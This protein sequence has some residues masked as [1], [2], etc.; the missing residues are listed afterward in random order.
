M[1]RRVIIVLIIL[2]LTSWIYMSKI[3]S[4]TKP[5]IQPKV[6]NQEE[7]V[8]KVAEPRIEAEPLPEPTTVLDYLPAVTGLTAEDEDLLV[9]EASSQLFSDDV[10]VEGF[11][12]H[13]RATECDLL[14]AEFMKYQLSKSE[15]GEGILSKKQEQCQQWKARFPM[16]SAKLMWNQKSNELPAMSQLGHLIRAFT[17]LTDP[18]ERVNYAADIFEQGLKEKNPYVLDYIMTHS[19]YVDEE[20]TAAFDQNN[21]YSD[22]VFST[23]VD[24]L[25]CEYSQEEF[26]GAGS[27]LMLNKC[28]S[29]ESYCGLTYQ[30]WFEQNFMPGMKQDVVLVL[31]HLKAQGQYINEK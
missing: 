22:L 6:L 16:L 9:S 26:C 3:T 2:A 20:L 12:L 10:Y 11:S 8:T 1:V 31:E 30:Q 21:A 23:A 4:Q 17:Q 15:K 28:S 18:I 14:D 27:W 5:Q 19:V 25:S 13:I 24:L 29:N 7:K